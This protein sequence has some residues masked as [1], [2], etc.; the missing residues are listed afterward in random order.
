LLVV[1]AILAVLIGLLLPAVQKVRE[2]ANRL[3]CQ[4][5]LK[6]IGLGLHNYHDTNN[7]FPPGQFNPIA[8]DLHPYNRACWE[9]PLLPFIEE[10]ALF[11]GIDNYLRVQN[12]PYACWAPNAWVP[13]KALM[14]PADPHAGKNLTSGAATPQDANVNQGFH[15]EYVLCAGSKVFNPSS[16][17]LGEHLN[18]MF[19]PLSKTKIASVTDGTS[20]TLMSSEIILVPDVIGVQFQPGPDL[21]LHDLRGRYYNTWQGNVLFTAL[22]PP[23]TS[24][25]DRSNYCRDGIVMQAP[26]ILSGTNTAQYARSYH[27]G[28]VNTGLADGSVRFISNNIDLLLYQ[29]LS[30][31]AGGE[32]VGGDF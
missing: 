10:A 14:C 29:A 9:L 7:V 22:Q 18:G 26:C 16:D 20:N 13:V 1:I 15:G 8:Q 6:Q 4:N 3:K 25:G 19:Y 32:A 21:S 30:T 11:Q 2:A 5:N 27:P 12:G 17:P 28:G 24:V 23:N 31:R